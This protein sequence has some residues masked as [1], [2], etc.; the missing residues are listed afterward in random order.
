MKSNANL[1]KKSPQM[2]VGLKLKL[3]PNRLEPL[4]MG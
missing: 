2:G 3:S 4:N 1:L